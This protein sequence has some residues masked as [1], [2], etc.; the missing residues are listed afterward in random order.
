MSDSE[1]TPQEQQRAR[2]LEDEKLRRWCAQ[3]AE[4]LQLDGVEVDLGSVL[5][6]A[7]R[8]AHSVLR[9]AAPLTTFLVGYAAAQMAA[10]PDTSVADAVARATDT[11]DRLCREAQSDSGHD[12]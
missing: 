4:A 1:P 3:L 5:G 12:E 11:A 6:L 8:A 9:P 7:G 10:N 2:E